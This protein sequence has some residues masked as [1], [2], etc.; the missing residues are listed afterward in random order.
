MNKKLYFGLSLVALLVSGCG[1][2]TSSSVTPSSSNNVSNVVPS[3]TSSSASQETSSKTSTPAPSTTISTTISSSETIN[4]YT[5]DF[6]VDGKSYHQ[7]KVEE[8]HKV[9][10]PVDPSKDG[11]IFIKWCVD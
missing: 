2:N 10:K 5:V 11:F 3:S 8:G 1:G 7:A 9:E 4:E 6:I